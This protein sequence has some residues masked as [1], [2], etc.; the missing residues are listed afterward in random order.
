[1]PCLAAAA[2]QK[3]KAALSSD[4]SKALKAFYGVIKDTYQGVFPAVSCETDWPK[5]LAVYSRNMREFR[6]KYPDGPGAIK[7][8]L[9]GSRSVCAGAPRPDVPADGASGAKAHKDAGGSLEQRI[10]AHIKNRKL[11]RGF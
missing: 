3:G 4:T 6:T 11:D 5:Y 8:I 1:M 9:P 7:G 2:Q 10:K